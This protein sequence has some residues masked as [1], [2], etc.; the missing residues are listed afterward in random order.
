MT[1][2]IGIAIF[3]LLALQMLEM[4]RSSLALI[5]A[6]SDRARLLAAADAGIAMAVHGLA[7]RDP[8]RRIDADG[9]AHIDYFDGVLL[10]VTVE[11][12]QGKIALNRVGPDVERRLFSAAGIDGARLD[13]IVDSLEDWKDYDDTQ[14]PH[15]AERQYYAALGIRPRNDK[16]R[17]LEELAVLPGMDDALLARIAPA[18][19]LFANRLGNFEA[20][21]SSSPLAL[22][23]MSGTGS[24]YE[25]EK[26]SA[27]QAGQRP[28]L[29]IVPARSLAE[30]FYTVKVE[31]SLPDGHRASRSV[32]V[33]F[34]GNPA[35]PFW[36][37]TAR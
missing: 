2:V 25:V 22:Q 12:D 37:R 29:D 34:N 13:E 35:N 32:V 14:R 33:Q 23:A 26:R 31:A 17:T 21:V 30:R 36:I 11:D 4:G 5:Q 6:R 27:L 3:A 10:A 16:I 15:G 28:A 18:V 8:A 9:V 24:A 19:T 20:G 1:A 7:V